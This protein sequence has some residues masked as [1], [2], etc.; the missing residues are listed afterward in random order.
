MWLVLVIVFIISTAIGGVAWWYAAHYDGLVGVTRAITFISIICLVGSG[1]GL[2]KNGFTWGS[3]NNATNSAKSSSSSK[4]LAN[5]QFF[6]ERDSE[7]TAAKNLANNE[8]A[9]LKQLNKMYVNQGPVT[10]DKATKTYTVTA[11][12]PKFKKAITTIWTYPSKNQKSL[13]SLKTNYLKVSKSINKT[14]KEQYTLQLK[15]ADG[16]VI[17]TVKN[18]T[19]TF[20]GLNN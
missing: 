2:W 17:I 19:V 15:N 18:G 7:Q 4:K 16:N 8:T 11:Q 5:S 13:T 1:V 9:V 10:F 20:S 3:S 14:L 12:K 6:A